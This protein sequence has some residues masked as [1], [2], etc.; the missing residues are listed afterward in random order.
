MKSERQAS[1]PDNQIN[2]IQ[3]GRTEGRHWENFCLTLITIATAAIA[4]TLFLAIR[5]G[6]PSAETPPQTPEAFVATLAGGAIVIYLVM[7]IV[8]AKSIFPNP[9]QTLSPEDKR[10]WASFVYSLFWT[11]IAILGTIVLLALVLSV[12][13]PWDKGIRDASSENEPPATPSHHRDTDLPNGIQDEPE[14]TPPQFQDNG[15]PEDPPE[16]PEVASP[17]SLPTEASGPPANQQNAEPSP[18]PPR[19]KP[20]GMRR[21][22]Q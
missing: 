17:E 14:A 11:Q 5:T 6:T 2:W 3:E 20:W 10:N 18:K 19:A 8:A 1:Q 16:S 12:F 22:I 15:F 4:A 13:L 7:G 21:Q 9:T